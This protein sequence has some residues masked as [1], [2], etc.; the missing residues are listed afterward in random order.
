MEISRNNKFLGAELAAAMEIEHKYRKQGY[1]VTR[2]YV[3]EGNRVDLYAEKDDIKF[4]FEFKARPFTHNERS[5]FEHIRTKAKEQGIH[6]RVVIVNVP[7]SKEIKVEGI[8]ETIFNSFMESIPDALDQLSPH[9]TIEG[10]ETV[11]INCIDIKSYDEIIIRGSSAV[12][13]TLNYDKDDDEGYT[14]SYP[15]TF[16]G[17]W[18]LKSSLIQLSHFNSLEINTNAFYK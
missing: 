13:V 18:S 2:D 9:T 4:I 1:T 8:E 7:R 6:F 16:E 12:T 11:E 15:F 10:I 14:D 5:Y 3:F 17:V